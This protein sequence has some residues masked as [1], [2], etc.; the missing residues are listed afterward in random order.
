MGYACGYASIENAIISMVVGAV[1]D[2]VV[3]AGERALLAVEVA[4]AHL[5]LLL[6]EEGDQLQLLLLVLFELVHQ[7]V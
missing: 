7:L 4:E 5:G 2:L 1:V 6:L 3:L